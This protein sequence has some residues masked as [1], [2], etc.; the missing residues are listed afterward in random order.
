MHFLP[1][2]H[3]VDL[4]KEGFGEDDLLERASFG[5]TLSNFVEKVEDPLVIDKE[6]ASF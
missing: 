4:Y 2:E 5:K 6:K 1:P 3:E